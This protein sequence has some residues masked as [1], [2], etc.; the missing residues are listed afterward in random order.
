MAGRFSR[1]WEILKASAAVLRQDK[2]LLIFPLISTVAAMGSIAAF[3]T[4]YWWW[5]IGEYG[6]T[7]GLSSY[8]PYALAFVF[9]FAAYLVVVYCNTAL[10][11]VATDHMG[12]ADPTIADGLRLAWSKVG[13][14]IGYASIAATVGVVLKVLQER[15]GPVGELIS[16]LTGIAWTVVTFLVI[17]VLVNRNVGPVDAVKES[18]HLLKET[19]GENIIANG[20]MS[21]VFSI[22]YIPFGFLAIVATIMAWP[23]FGYLDAGERAIVTGTLV[24]VWSPLVVLVALHGALQGIYSAA[25]YRFATHASDEATGTS[26]AP[27]LLESAFRQRD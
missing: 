2:K 20:G 13:T 17:P 15:L 9:Y 26:M 14:V 24:L 1:S 11:A 6:T 8:T 3:G 22:L 7:D 18:A 21:L 4:V 10:V 5:E 25:L 27:I 16:G 19:W 23:G 12:N